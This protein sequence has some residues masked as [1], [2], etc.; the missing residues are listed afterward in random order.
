MKKRVLIVRLDAI[1]DYVLWRNCLGFLRNCAKYRDAHLTV[2]GNPVWRNLAETFDA[3]C[4]DEWIWVENRG[5]LFRRGWENLLPRMVWHRRVAAAQARLKAMLV[6]RGF[7]E[8]ISPCAFPDALLDELV[9]GI[10]PISISVANGDKA[11]SSRFSRLVNSGVDPFVFCRNRAIASAMAGTQCDVQLELSVEDPP[12]KTNRVLFFPGASHWTRRWPARRWRKLRK[13]APSG[14]ETVLAPTGTTLAE[15]VR[16]VKSCAAVVSNDTMAL[17]V[18][19]ALGVPAVGIVNGVSG[20]SD[21]WPYP[22]SLGKNVEVCFPKKIPRV[23]ISLLGS[24][25]A[26]YIAL[27]SVSASSVADALRRVLEV[28]S[29]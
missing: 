24:R 14:F 22:A 6:S 17:H 26:Q 10:A 29:P 19:A 2:L 20:R 4:A 16:L 25:L 5:E 1:G 12:A 8:V 23:P 15:F 21:F 9:V 11:R 27:S 7:D 13:M 28:Q 3:D 18:A